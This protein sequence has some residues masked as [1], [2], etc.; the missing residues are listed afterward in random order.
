VKKLE[1]KSVKVFYQKDGQLYP[2]VTH[3][4]DIK[5]DE[6]KRT[7][8]EWLKSLFKRQYKAK[9]SFTVKLSEADSDY[10]FA[11]FFL[12]DQLKELREKWRLKNNIK[13]RVGV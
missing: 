9:G 11:K 12:K 8:K 3:D 10:F 6:P 5:I 13:V 4:G 7:F 1:P 2:L